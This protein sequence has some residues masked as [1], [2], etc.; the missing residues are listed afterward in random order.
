MPFI[1][2]QFLNRLIAISAQLSPLP[3]NQT[4]NY[5]A[6]ASSS[7]APSSIH[8]TEADSISPLLSDDVELPSGRSAVTPMY[9]PDQSGVKD[10]NEI[11][12]ISVPVVPSGSAGDEA[13]P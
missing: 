3:Y 2:P 5:Q 8:A 7:I 9:K 4:M 1:K 10:P 11:V 13:A 12:M 6:D